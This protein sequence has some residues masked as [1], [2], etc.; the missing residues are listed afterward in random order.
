MGVRR[1]NRAEQLGAQRR[2]QRQ[3]K[4]NRAE[5]VIIA[6]E[7]PCRGRHPVAQPQLQGQRFRAVRPR[8]AVPRYAREQ[9]PA[10]GRGNQEWGHVPC[11]HAEGGDEDQRKGDSERGDDEDWDD[12]R[13]PG[14]QSA[15][16]GVGTVLGQGP[17][18][19]QAQ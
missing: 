3:G 1:V 15:G 2:D 12:G 8:V 18:G 13:H 9:D 19:G 6:N 7:K 10:D 4:G 5:V 17:S 16:S 14:L 11:A